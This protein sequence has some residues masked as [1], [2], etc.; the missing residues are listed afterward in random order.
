[1]TRS[2]DASDSDPLATQ[3]TKGREPAR[4][5]YAPAFASGPISGP[6]QGSGR[7]I[8]IVEDEPFVA[9]SLQ[10]ALNELG[11][12]VVA[13]VADV[14]T[15]IEAV[16]RERLDVALL[17]VKLGAERVDAV[18]DLLARRG[19]PFVFT[20]GFDERDIPPGHEGRTVL[21]KPFGSAQLVSALES[22]FAR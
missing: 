18:A 21:R 13:C 1:M 2:G 9:V 4:R 5:A 15:A 16:A 8:L 10:D 17:D 22:V 19:C 3:P 6:A 12:D 14:R 20:T 11:F 7:R